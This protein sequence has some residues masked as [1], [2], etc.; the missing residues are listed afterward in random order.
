MHVDFP[1]DPRKDD[2]RYAGHR[3]DPAKAGN[4]PSAAKAGLPVAGGDRTPHQRRAGSTATPSSPRLEL[5]LTQ[6]L[7]S[8]GAAVTA[9]FLGSRL[10]VAG[11]LIGAALASV[12]SVVGGALYTTS[13]KATRQR[14]TMLVGRGEEPG[15]NSPGTRSALGLVP[16]APPAGAQGGPDVRVAAAPGRPVRGRRPVL[17]GAVA[18]VLLSAAV[19]TG[20]LLVVTGVESVTGSALSGGSAGSL[21]I[22]GGNDA[23]RSDTGPGAPASGSSTDPSPTRTAAPAS[24]GTSTSGTAVSTAAASTTAGSSPLPAST[25]TPA[26]PTTTATPSATSTSLST[27]PTSAATTGSSAAPGTPTRGQGAP[28]TGTAAGGG[29][30]ATGTVGSTPPP[31]ITSSSVGSPAGTTASS[32]APTPARTPEVARP[33]R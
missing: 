9:A 31:E 14:V 6:I 7:G 18:G 27:T 28:T 1:D 23:G 20:A 2:H 21:T 4:G 12:I 11:T 10:G 26:T 19:F 29:P 24:G 3:G 17:R 30:G 8:T 33:T 16:G 5:S 32:A 13:L 25:S 22:L 15:S